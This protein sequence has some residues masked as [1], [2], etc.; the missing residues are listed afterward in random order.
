MVTKSV[1]VD[2]SGREHPSREAAI[3]A[4]YRALAI[5]ALDIKS[6]SKVEAGIL[7]EGDVVDSFLRIKKEKRRALLTV[8]AAMLDDLEDCNGK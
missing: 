8:L 2:G 3:V 6:P 1:W 4:D 7:Y 5:K